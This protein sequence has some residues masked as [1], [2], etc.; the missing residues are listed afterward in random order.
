MCKQPVMVE[1]EVRGRNSL[2]HTRAK[3][4]GGGR[5]GKGLLLCCSLGQCSGC[6]RV[7]QVESFQVESASPVLE[8]VPFGL[9]GASAPKEMT[10]SVWWC[11]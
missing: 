4:F 10:A 3:L 2:L 9:K 11:Y 8:R 5:K 1:T 7:E 6:C